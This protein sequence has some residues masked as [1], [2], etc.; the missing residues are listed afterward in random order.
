M[1]WKYLKQSKMAEAAYLAVSLADDAAK[2]A[3]EYSS[4]RFNRFYTFL[5]IKLV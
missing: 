1:I 4:Q 2:Q 3:S 5:G